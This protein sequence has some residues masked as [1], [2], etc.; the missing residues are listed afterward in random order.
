MC[1][2]VVQYCFLIVD[3]NLDLKPHIVTKGIKRMT[4]E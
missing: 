3:I 1:I 2:D 4:Y